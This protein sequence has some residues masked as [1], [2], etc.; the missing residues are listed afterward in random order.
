MLI[1][2]LICNMICANIFTV[3]INVM[4][5]A[6]TPWTNCGG[7]PFAKAPSISFGWLGSRLPWSWGLPCW[8]SGPSFW[9]SH[10]KCGP[11]RMFES[12]FCSRL[13]QY[14]W[15]VWYNYMWKSIYCVRVSVLLCCMTLY[16]IMGYIIQYYIVYRNC[17]WGAPV[18]QEKNNFTRVLGMQFYDMLLYVFCLMDWMDPIADSWYILSLLGHWDSPGATYSSCA[19]RAPSTWRP[20]PLRFGNAWRRCSNLRTLG[21]DVCL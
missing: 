3:I 17:C 19:A 1:I 21:G 4:R 8:C 2:V 6:A 13:C 15:R 12:V 9:A 5:I 11:G 7:D 18:G 14:V 20:P 10:P 16:A